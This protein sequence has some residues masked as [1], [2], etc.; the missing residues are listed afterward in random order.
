MYQTVGHMGVELYAE[1]MGLPLFRQNTDGKA[2][3]QEKDYTPTAD[4]EVEDLFTLLS[5][6]KVSLSC[7]LANFWTL[8]SVKFPI[9]IKDLAW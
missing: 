2:V 8:T 5:R 1:A 9:F 4:D 6:V 7:S 3:R